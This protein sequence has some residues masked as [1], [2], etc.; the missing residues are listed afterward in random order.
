M[1]H[2]AL[3]CVLLLGCS[4]P[5]ESPKTGTPTEGPTDSMG[6]GNEPLVSE[7][8]GPRDTLVI[9]GLSDAEHL[10]DVVHSTVYDAQILSAIH[11]GS[12]D[13]DFECKLNYKPAL[14]KTFDFNDDQ[15]ILSVTLRD[16]ITW[17]DG[18][19]V[20]ASDIAF[21]FDLV[22]DKAVASPRI[23]A[24]ERMVE[25][26]GPL[27]TGDHSLEF[28]FKYPYNRIT[29]LAHSSIVG[30]HPKHLLKDADRATLRG[31]PLTRKPV[32]T[33]PWRLDKWE[34]GSRLVLVPNEKFTGPK[35]FH[36]RLKRIIYKTVP[37]YAARLVELENGSIDL[38]ESILIQDIDRLVAEHP[39]IKNLSP[40]LAGDGL[41]GLEPS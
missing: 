23:Q 38:M 3:L 29:M 25:G 24:T 17:Q 39:E 37:E 6:R 11:F 30:P 13:A 22:R 36:P 15:T 16:D 20:T 35:E 7:L 28:H 32:A 4:K 2:A 1:R 19:P 27:V 14:Y 31:H 9:G 8:G 41:L 40:R 34:P 33:G 26:K 21:A 5:S 10:L 12:V 18:T